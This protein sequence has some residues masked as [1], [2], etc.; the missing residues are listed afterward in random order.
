MPTISDK[1]EIE[2]RVQA[3]LYTVMLWVEQEKE[4]SPC[5]SLKEAIK[6]GQEV[7]Q[8]STSRRNDEVHPNLILIDLV[9]KN[10]SDIY[11]RSSANATP[12]VTPVS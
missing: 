10:L 9:L 3:N 12:G 11:N 6:V 2:D 1:Q 7:L 5:E 8:K 4:L